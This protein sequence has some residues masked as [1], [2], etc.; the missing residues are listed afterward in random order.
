M[1]VD[2]VTSA[3]SIGEH[4]VE[5]VRRLATPSAGLLLR[6]D[7]APSASWVRR[8]LKR[9]ADG[10]GAMDLHLM[11]AGVYMEQA[12]ALDDQVTVFYVDNHLRPYT[13]KHVIRRGW[14]MQDKRVLPGTTDYYVHDEDGRPVLRIPAWSNDSL[15]TWLSPIAVL[16]R[17][18]LGE[19]QRILLAFDRAG[20]YPTQL[21]E[22]R[23]FD[24]E[25]VTYERRPYPLLSPGV[26]TE[27]VKYGD[28]VIGFHERNTNLGRARGRVRRIALRMEDGYQVNLL[29]VS[30]EPAERLIGIMLGRWCQENAFKHGVERWGINQ[31]DGRTVRPYPEGAVIP[32]PARRR[33]DNALRLARV[34]EG[35]V[36]QTSVG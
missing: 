28:E 21:V 13:G 6:S 15:T 33:L 16:F 30:K 26:F 35:L 34:E 36:R 14:R 10:T 11:M 2:A 8:V 1:A 24:F 18:A 5:G 32:N 20:A 22:L 31:L 27:Q 12:Q 23:D 25:F 3:L 7:H 9:L 4:C 17:E 19:R 29:A